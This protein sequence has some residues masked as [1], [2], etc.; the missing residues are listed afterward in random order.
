MQGAWSTGTVF[1]HVRHT[2]SCRG[3]LDHRL[4]VLRVAD[5]RSDCGGLL[6][7]I[8]RDN[9]EWHKS[10]V[11]SFL[12]VMNFGAAGEG[13]VDR[14]TMKGSMSLSIDGI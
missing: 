1:V 8:S 7:K 3:V 5:I 4:A 11:A 2:R 12:L 6:Q 13:D 14:Q 10:L 9:T